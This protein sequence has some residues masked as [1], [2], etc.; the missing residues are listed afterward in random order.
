VLDLINSLVEKLNL[1]VIMISHDIGAIATIAKRCA[2]M[3]KG[4]IV[5]YGPPSQIFQAPAHAYTQRLV[6]AIPGGDWEASA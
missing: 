1:T 2:V 3:Y 4:E 6:A 5:E